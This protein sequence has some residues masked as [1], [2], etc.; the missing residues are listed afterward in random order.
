MLRGMS[1]RA[2]VRVEL[3]ASTCPIT[4]PLPT[5]FRLLLFNLSLFLP[6]LTPCAPKVYLHHTIMGG[7]GGGRGGGNYDHK[8][9]TSG[10]SVLRLI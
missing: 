7:E 9:P 1:V 2:A 4:V 6:F 8:Y 10:C 3:V 5:F